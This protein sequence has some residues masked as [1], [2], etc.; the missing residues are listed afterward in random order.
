MTQCCCCAPDLLQVVSTDHAGMVCCWDL[1][2][3]RLI[4]SFSNTHGSCRISAAAFD[5]HCRRLITGAED[6]SIKVWNFRSGA[7]LSTVNTSC[8]NNQQ[9]AAA[10][11]Q[12]GSGSGVE[13]T[14]LAV[15]STTD[16][17]GQAARCIVAAGWDRKVRGG[18]LFY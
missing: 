5:A 9:A 14:G 4:K 7:L 1:T 15:A 2:T 3:G 13:V 6:G 11:S 12:C 8:N 17:N 18:P 16:T 10:K